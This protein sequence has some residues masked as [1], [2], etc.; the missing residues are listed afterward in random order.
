MWLRIGGK[1]QNLRGETS[2]ASFKVSIFFYFREALSL[3]CSKPWED[4]MKILTGQRLFDIAPMQEY[5]RPLL[6]WLKEQNKGETIGWTGQ[7]TGDSGSHKQ[8]SDSLKDEV[9]EEL[10]RAIIEAEDNQ[11]YS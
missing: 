1:V 2:S 11:E 3:G 6:K 5:F 4:V 7:D 9:V 8:D 10:L